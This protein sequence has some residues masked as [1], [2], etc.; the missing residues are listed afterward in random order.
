LEFNVRSQIK[1]LIALSSIA[2]TIGAYGQ[3]KGSPPR[4][5]AKA[6]ITAIEER[7]AGQQTVDNVL[8]SWDKDAVWYDIT[9]GDVVGIDAIRQ[10]FAKAVFNSR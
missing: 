7:M 4:Q 6:A 3:S 9:P 10:D 8:G 2:L 1:I 5:G